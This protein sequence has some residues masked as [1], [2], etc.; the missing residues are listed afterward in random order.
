MA[1]LFYFTEKIQATRRELSHAP[2]PNLTSY[3]HQ[4]TY[5]PFGMN[6][7]ASLHWALI[8]LIYMYST[9]YLTLPFIYLMDSLKM[10]KKE[11][12]FPFTIRTTT[13]NHT[14]LPAVHPVLVNDSLHPPVFQIINL[15]PISNPSGSP[16]YSLSLLYEYLTT[17]LSFWYSA[18]ASKEVSLF[19]PMSHPF[20]I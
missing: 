17:F 11:S 13:T 3:L 20:S 15:C 10:S 4:Y 19:L 12:C 9:L 2:T 1:L 7:F 6:G 8:S 16:L 5:L 18:F 14:T